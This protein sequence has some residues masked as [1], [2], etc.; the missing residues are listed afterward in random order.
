MGSHEYL[1]DCTLEKLM[2]TE[3]GR[4][5]LAMAR[6][7]LNEGRWHDEY[8]S[9]IGQQ[10][11]TSPRSWPMEQVACFAEVHALIF[12]GDA[13]ELLIGVGETPRPDAD[14][15]GNAAALARLPHP[16]RAHV[17]MEQNNASQDGTLCWEGPIRVGLCTGLIARHA[18]GTTHPLPVFFTI[19][20]G[21]APLEIGSTKPSRTL[22]H[23]IDGE[24]SV[25]RWPYGSSRIRLIVNLNHDT[26]L[27]NRLG[28][29]IDKFMEARAAIA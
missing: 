16:F 6:E 13:T 24:G 22:A 11:L 14:R 9:A 21:M 18:D 10:S 4:L 26:F 23:L 15:E 5:A 28:S 7:G 29:F 8:L 3:D 1:A 2:R 19:P 27:G 17:D 25:A 12:G 20:A